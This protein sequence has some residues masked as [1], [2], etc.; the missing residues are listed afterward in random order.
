MYISNTIDPLVTEVKFENNYSESVWL[1]VTLRGYWD[2]FIEVLWLLAYFNWS[3][4]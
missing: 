2:A 3:G 4:L 1:K